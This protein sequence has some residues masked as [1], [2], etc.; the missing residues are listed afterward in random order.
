MTPA[1]CATSEQL[2]ALLEERLTP[3]EFRR[4]DRHL[5]G[6]TDCL[7]RLN[8]LAREWEQTKLPGL[9]SAEP[10][11]PYPTFHAR[12]ADDTQLDISTDLFIGQCRVLRE[13]GRG[14]M[15]V[16]YEGLHRRLNRLVAV[17]VLALPLVNRKD[18]AIRFA[19][20]IRAMAR[21]KH[22]G[23]VA[24]YDGGICRSAPGQ[25]EVP[26][27][28]LELV[29]GPSLKKYLTDRG[30]LTPRAAVELLEAVARAVQHAHVRGVI[31]RDLK[32]AN[33]LL[34]EQFE[35]QNAKGEQEQEESEPGSDFDFRDL[36]FF[37]K[38]TDFGLAKFR[39]E[40]CGLTPAR[41]LLGTPEYMCPEL[42]EE[43]HTLDHRMDVYA[44]GVILF[45]CLTGQVPF[46]ASSPVKTLLMARSCKPVAPSQINIALPPAL[47]N[48]VLKCLA[49]NPNERYQTASAFADDLRRYLRGEFEPP[50][51][52]RL[53]VLIALSVLAVA[54]VIVSLGVGAL[55]PSARRPTLP[56][57]GRPQQQPKANSLDLEK[58]PQ[59]PCP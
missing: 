56:Q 18:A 25:P 58:C 57:N 30:P 46:R 50:S 36:P 23:I 31:H 5:R 17:K 44:L 48:I 26:F 43:E 2:E 51:F 10:E 42:G 29:Q 41:D 16:V 6:C 4:I 13:I 21:L 1:A 54:A 27:A 47:D 19:N 7:A 49:K 53:G 24:V 20:E 14:G 35:V 28:V 40:S 32:P 34:T 37:P 12:P 22:P 45:E 55:S 39:D 38:V 11:T 15:G 9:S 59:F 33:I 8:R 52:S 3:D